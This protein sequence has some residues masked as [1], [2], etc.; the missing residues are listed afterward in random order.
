M[1]PNPAHCLTTAIQ[2]YERTYRSATTEMDLCQLVSVTSEWCFSD[3]INSV[4]FLKLVFQINDTKSN[5][6][7]HHHIQ[8]PTPIPTLSFFHCPVSQSCRHNSHVFTSSFEAVES[9]IP[10]AVSSLVRWPIQ[11]ISSAQRKSFPIHN[12]NEF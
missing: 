9:S 10:I 5:E 11:V 2:G 6:E 7:V 1:V 4:T 8:C 12:V 3:H